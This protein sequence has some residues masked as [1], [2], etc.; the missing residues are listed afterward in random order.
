[1]NVLIADD[2]PIFRR[3]LQ[4]LLEQWGFVCSTVSNGIAALEELQRADAPQLA[5]LDWTM[6]GLDG[7]Q[8]VQKLRAGR[9]Q[10]YTYVLLLTAK[11][12]K[13][14]VIEALRAGCDDYL[15]KPF[16]PEEL[17]ARLFVGKRILALEAQLTEALKTTQYQ[18]SHDALTG[19]NNRAAVLEA[20]QRELQRGSRQKDQVSV[21]MLDLDHFKAVNDSYGHL[22]GDQVLQE[23]AV[24][25][26]NCL[27][28]YD[29]AGRFGGEEFL[30]VLPDCRT[31]EAIGVANRIAESLR[32]TPVRALQENL[33]ITASMGVA[34]SKDG[35]EM[36]A[37]LHAADC[38]LY[39][40]KAAGRDR[41]ESQEVDSFHP[42]LMSE[43]PNRETLCAS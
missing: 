42:E 35:T 2:D 10:P 26:K 1:M 5:V 36:Q 4:R 24:R 19:I 33:A 31:V 43:R 37:L 22:A 7:L 20:L 34:T 40:A 15:S 21:I 17:Q 27:R 30:V 12:K 9:A 18:A 29:L 38:A 39:K 23:V 32:G 3:L 13:C 16:D 11:H 41:V 8:V 6:P 25:L 14:E 28:G